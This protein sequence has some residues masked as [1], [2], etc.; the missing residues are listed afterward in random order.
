ML[1]L[2][3]ILKE[4]QGEAEESDKCESFNNLANGKKYAQ[5]YENYVHKKSVYHNARGDTNVC[6]KDRKSVRQ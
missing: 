3:L 1:I 6:V 5:K 4:S 2:S